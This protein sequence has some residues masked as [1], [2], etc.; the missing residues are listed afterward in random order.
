MSTQFAFHEMPE[1]PHDREELGSEATAL[2]AEYLP[3]LLAGARARGMADAFD[4][5]GK[6]A[7]LIGEAGTT[8]HVNQAAVSKL[9]GTLA[10]VSRHLIGANAAANSALQAMIADAV[11]GRTHPR[12]T[13][14][15][16]EGQSSLIVEA[17][18]IVGAVGDPNQILKAIVVISDEAGVRG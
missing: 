3:P 16:V 13:L 12:I 2:P 18:P 17:L 5:M 9:G 10:V 6:A 4:L 8:L 15:A 1:Q 7:I 11:A 14:A